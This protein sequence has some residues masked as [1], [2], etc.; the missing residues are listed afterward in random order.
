M[1]GRIV[2]YVFLLAIVSDVYIFFTYIKKLTKSTLLRA[3]WFLPSIILLFC[4]YFFFFSGEDYASRDTFLIVFIA[5]MFPKIFFAIISLLDLPLRY[6]FKWKIYPFTVLGLVVAIGVFYI[7]IY[8]SVI[9]KT[10][11]RVNEVEFDSVN[12]PES[13]NNYKIVQVS[14]LHIGNWKDD[15]APIKKVVELINQQ[16]PDIVFVTGDLVHHA[17][18]ELDGFE[19]ILSKIKAPDGVYSV[20]GNHDYGPYYRWDSEEDEIF[21]LK[22]LKQRQ[23]DMGWELLNNTHVYLVREKDS[24][25]LIGVE[26]DGAPPFS[27]YG[28]LPKAM[29]G[30]NSVRFK[31]LLSHDPTHWRREVLNTDIDLMFAGHTHGTQLALGSFSIASFVYPEWGGLY[32]EGNQGLYVNV[33]IGHVGIP[34]RFGAWPEITVMTLK[35]ADPKE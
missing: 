26:N 6:F 18:T 12:L 10:D 5:A 13:F 19:D 15:R 11:F 1:F 17:A 31:M 4:V 33:G 2:V 21:N 14:D 9:G 28:D 25:A 23:T 34:F 8:G 3:L 30:M 7:V 16:Q 20:L 24:I 27:K 32:K 35:T 22:D 29:N